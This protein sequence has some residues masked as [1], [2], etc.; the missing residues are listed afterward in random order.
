MKNITENEYE[1]VARKRAKLADGRM[2]WTGVMRAAY[3]I[4]C[5]VVGVGSDFISIPRAYQEGAAGGSS[6]RAYAKLTSSDD[7]RSSSER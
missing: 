1:V 2:G 6:E 3:A 7:I 4:D 5:T